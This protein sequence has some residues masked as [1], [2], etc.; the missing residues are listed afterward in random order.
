MYLAYTDDGGTRDKKAA[1]QVVCTLIAKD[2]SIRYLEALA[3]LLAFDLVP[4]SKKNQFEEFHAWEL[5]GGYGVFDGVDQAHRFQTIEVFLRTLSDEKL[6]IVY[7][8]VDKSKLAQTLYATA[9]PIAICFQVCMNGTEQWIAKSDNEEL[10]LLIV[11]DF[12]SNKEIKKTLRQ[13]F[14]E[15]RTKLRS[16]II[17]VGQPWHLHDD[18]YFGS[19]TDSVGIQ[20]ADLCCFFIRKHHEGRDPVAET[21]YQM[22][23]DRIVFSRV[24][25]QEDAALV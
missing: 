18:M 23:R 20:L 5:Y 25:P 12:E 19:S 15:F 1:Y 17:P 7:G 2:K 9:D 14:R 24:L 16:V 4:E 11:D 8:A 13:A 21:F 6:S 10:G 22:I 3:G